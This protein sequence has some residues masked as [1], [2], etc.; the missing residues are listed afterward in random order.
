MELSPHDYF[1]QAW[2]ALDGQLAG[3]SSFPLGRL[4]AQ[5][6]YPDPSWSR[7]LSSCLMGI[8][9]GAASDAQLKLRVLGQKQLKV[10]P[11]FPLDPVDIRPGGRLMAWNSQQFQ[12]LFLRDTITLADRRRGQAIVYYPQPGTIPLWD[13]CAPFR[14][15]L[16]FLL[17]GLG[18]QLV[19]GSALSM[20]S[21]ACLL[22]GKGGSGKSSTALAALAPQ[23]GLDFIAEDYVLVEEQSLNAF[24]LFSS[25]KVDSQG[26]KRMPWLQDF[27]ILGQVEAKFCGCIPTERLAGKSHLCF[28][29]WPDLLTTST[30]LAISKS[31]A[32]LKLAP[33]TL[34]Q[35]HNS[36]QEELRSLAKLAR[37]LSTYS[38]G[39]GAK[40]TAYEVTAQLK[41]LLSSN[42]QEAPS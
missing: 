2:A 1:A 38:L 25:F 16:A 17:P 8:S 42:P 20:G 32:L 39:L 7:P 23:S 9:L 19:H 11:P 41:A 36:G 35:N 5:V 29:I 3:A 18:Y 13:V 24:S 37:G 31:Q 40:P 14:N 21:Q 4:K 27:P 28:L 15:P 12:A 6:E 22:V 33:S 34:I 26:L 30:L 10:M